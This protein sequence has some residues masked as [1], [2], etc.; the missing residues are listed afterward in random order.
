MHRPPKPR[1]GS[2]SLSGP[3]IFFGS[4][5][6]ESLQNYANEVAMEFRKVEWPSGKELV[7][8]TIVVFIVITIFSLYVFGCDAIISALISEIIG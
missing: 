1:I 7:N 2:S 3:V 8:S 4:N 6:L 5:M